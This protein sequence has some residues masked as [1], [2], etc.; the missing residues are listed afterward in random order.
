[1]WIRTR[2]FIVVRAA[3]TWSALFLIF[4]STANGWTVTVPVRRAT[5]VHPSLSSRLRSSSRR[6]R[7]IRE[8]EHRWFDTGLSAKADRWE[9]D[10]GRL[11]N[12][13]DDRESGTA[14]GS[15][16]WRTS[17]NEKPNGTNGG[18]RVRRFWRAVRTFTRSVT[19]GLTV[20]V[21][22]CEHDKYYVGST[23]HRRR[24]F[25]HHLKEGGRSGRSGR[26]TISLYA[27]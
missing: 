5:I 22:E 14:P 10:G 11:A 8:R 13:T 26:G 15:R 24:R 20:Y 19:E 9:T 4:C 18:S 16:L 6:R 17:G 27:C 3:L 12:G 21:L 23:N 1:M 7:W 25:R 2:R